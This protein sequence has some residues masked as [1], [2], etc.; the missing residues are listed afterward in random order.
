M[1]NVLIKGNV[2]LSDRII[3]NAILRCE[4]GRIIRIEEFTPKH[5]K[6]PILDYTGHYL[7]PG[8]VDIHVHGA[9]GADYMDGTI[10]AVRTTNIA[11]AR[12]GTTSIFP[13][14]TTGSFDQLD[15]M[16]KACENVQSSWTP[17]DG[18]RIAE[19]TSTVLILPKARLGFTRQKAGAIRCVKSMSISCRRRLSRLQPVHPSY[20]ARW[21]S[22]ILPG[23]RVP[24]HVRTFQCPLERA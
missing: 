6:E 4:E 17:A 7:S 21:I 5:L 11:H 20:P 14:T 12:H 10:D 2:I 15:A 8:F 13:T 18:A 19:S 16:V 23:K 1:S 3:E 9:A 24:D 22:S